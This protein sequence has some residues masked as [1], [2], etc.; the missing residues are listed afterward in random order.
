VWKS[1]AIFNWS[2]T[3]NSVGVVVGSL[4][5]PHRYV[6]S[7]SQVRNILPLF[8]CQ[9]EEEANSS[10]LFSREQAPSMVQ[11][12]VCYMEKLVAETKQQEESKAQGFSQATLRDMRTRRP[13]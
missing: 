9:R 12:F 2:S 6:F 5:N 13:F 8:M 10:G 7:T 11:T 3:Q 1:L 4:M